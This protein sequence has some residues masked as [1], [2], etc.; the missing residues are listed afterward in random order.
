MAGTN[1]SS[2]FQQVGGHQCPPNDAL[3]LNNHSYRALIFSF[4]NEIHNVISRLDA[5]SA[6]QQAMTDAHGMMVLCV[7]MTQNCTIPT[8]VMQIKFSYISYI[9]LFVWV[10]G[11]IKKAFC[12][13]IR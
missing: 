13:F 9:S 5:K 3:L 10:K 4:L 2:H 11:V 8:G 6:A 7:D 12:V 1:K